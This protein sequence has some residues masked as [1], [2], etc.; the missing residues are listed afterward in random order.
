MSLWIG[1]FTTSFLITYSYFIALFHWLGHQ[2]KYYIKL[3][4]YPCI[5]LDLRKN[6]LLAIGFSRWVFAWQYLVINSLSID[7]VIHN[8]SKFISMMLFCSFISVF[9][10]WHFKI[11]YHMNFFKYVFQF[12]LDQLSQP[13]ISCI[14]TKVRV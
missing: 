13:I 9:M 14:I 8:F 10:C 11:F 3:R 7:T 12:G 1:S 6:V 2:I 4:K 5:D